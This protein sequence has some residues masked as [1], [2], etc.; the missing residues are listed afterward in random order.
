MG[1]AHVS[2][3]DSRGSPVATLTESSGVGQRRGWGRGGAPGRPGD[4]PSVCSPSTSQALWRALP[5]DGSRLPD[6]RQDARR[7]GPSPRRPGRRSAASPRSPATGT[8]ELTRP[9]GPAQQPLPGGAPPSPPIPGRREDARAGSGADNQSCRTQS[10]SRRT[11]PVPAIEGGKK[12]PVGAKLWYSAAAQKGKGQAG[13]SGRGGGAV[14]RKLRHKA[15]VRR[16]C[17]GAKERESEA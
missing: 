3:A 6:A 11:Q 4:A 5:E 9:V 14:P 15:E 16:V 10:T 2:A 8:Q 7:R 13:T 12:I 1:T 17:V